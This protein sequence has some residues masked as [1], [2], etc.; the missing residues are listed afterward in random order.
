M[1]DEEG[2]RHDESSPGAQ[3][4]SIAP[5]RNSSSNQPN[6]LRMTTAIGSVK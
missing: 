6:R 5:A 3:H 4:A 1:W 2:Q